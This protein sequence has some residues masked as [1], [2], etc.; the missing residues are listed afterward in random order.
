MKKRENAAWFY[1]ALGSLAVSVLSFLLPVLTYVTPEGEHW[2]F[3]L[4]NLIFYDARLTSVFLDYHG[5]VIVFLTERSAV[6]LGVLALAAL[7]VALVGLITLR[8]QRPN[9]RQ[10]VLTIIGL[11]LIL[12]PSLVL[13]VCVAVFGKYYAGTIGFGVAPILAPVS[14]LI[15]IGAVMRRKNRVA[16]EMRREME[17][18]GLIWQAGDLK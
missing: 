18:N 12:L 1:V 10:F 13:I 6:V 8:A 5:P 11:V 2:S 14:L 9:T 3:S 15:C 7:V 16:E 4:P 17:A